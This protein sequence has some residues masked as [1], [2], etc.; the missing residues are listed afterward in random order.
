MYRTD[1][2]GSTLNSVNVCDPVMAKNIEATTGAGAATQQGVIDFYS[3]K[4]TLLVQYSNSS[5]IKKTP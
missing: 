4:G 2:V 1:V 3:M 5:E